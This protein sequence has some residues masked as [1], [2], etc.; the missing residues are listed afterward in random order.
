[1]PLRSA[2]GPIGLVVF[3]A[4]AGGCNGYNLRYKADPQPQG[5]TLF[6]DFTP[7][8]DAVAAVVDTD[9]RRLEE[10]FVR[11]ADGSVVRPVNVIYP[12][13][14]KSAALGTGLGVGAGHVGIGTGLSI[15]I[16]PERAH[17]LT[18]ATFAATALGPAPWELHVKVQGVP[19]AVVPGVGGP[20]TAK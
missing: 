19:E 17:G 20:A 15:P 1:M 9:G 5:A 6:A 10:I 12:G 18:T 2:L 16:G 4:A 7:L 14:G 11:R 3:A 8:Q 13:F